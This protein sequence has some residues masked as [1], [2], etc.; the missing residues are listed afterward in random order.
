MYRLS[1]TASLQ[2]FVFFFGCVKR[3]LGVTMISDF[4]GA[5][6]RLTVQMGHLVNA[7]TIL[8]PIPTIASAGLIDSWLLTLNFGVN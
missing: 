3:I 6:L 7:E 2:L 4:T 8:K 5:R 1:K